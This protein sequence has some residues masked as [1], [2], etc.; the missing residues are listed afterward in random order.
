[1]IHTLSAAR[2]HWQ[3]PLKQILVLLLPVLFVFQLSLQPAQATSL[4]DLP[5]VPDVDQTLV[6]D[7]AN[8]LSRINKS[9]LKNQL[10]DLQ[11]NMGS[12]VHLVSVQRVESGGSTQGFADALFERWFPTPESQA[13]KIVVMVDTVTNTGGIHV[14]SASAELL[15]PQ[16]A[17]SVARET[18]VVPA[19]ESRYNQA[20]FDVIE[21]LSAVLSNQP[22]PGPPIVETV[23]RE[24]TFATPE[25]T[26]QSNGTRTVIILLVVATVVP[27]ATY[28]AFTS[29]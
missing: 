28:F 1:M 21:R 19:R 29:R 12:E 24:R 14:G 15:V 16:I 11:K 6:L 4:F 17:T 10:L 18:L 8:V 9:Q 3:K 27:M 22:D 26:K 25:E 20:M 13:N 5:P 7:A 2:N 23:V